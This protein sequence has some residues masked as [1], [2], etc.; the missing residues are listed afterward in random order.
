VG[1]C[2]GTPLRAEIEARAPGRLSGVTDDAARAVAARLG[3]GPVDS[4]MQAHVIVA[5]R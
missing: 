2:Q 1:F 3:D 4:G 5:T